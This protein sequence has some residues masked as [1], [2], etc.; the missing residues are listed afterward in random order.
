[1]TAFAYEQ[2]A[3]KHRT[4]QKLTEPEWEALLAGEREKSELSDENAAMVNELAAEVEKLE[5]Q[6][7]ALRYPND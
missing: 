7:D 6:L 1:M 3:R 2:A 4:G 5:A